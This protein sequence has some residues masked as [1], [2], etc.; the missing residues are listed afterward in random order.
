MSF[1]SYFAF[2]SHSQVNGFFFLFQRFA[3]SGT[4]G[5]TVSFEG[6]ETSQPN[7]QDKGE[8]EVSWIWF[9]YKSFRQRPKSFRICVRLVPLLL[10]PN[11][12][13]KER[14]TYVY[15]GIF[16]VMAERT[17]YIPA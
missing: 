8:W 4:G 6:R 10:S 11:Q 3:G 15:I 13:L 9:V 2:R 5:T 17:R 7:A 12:W 16:R 1:S 14:G